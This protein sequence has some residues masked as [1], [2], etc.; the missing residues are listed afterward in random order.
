[1]VEEPL[2][3]FAIESSSTY[4]GL[5]RVL[6]GALAP[7][8]GV[9]PDM[10]R[11]PELLRRAGHDSPA[12]EEVIIATRADSAGNATAMYLWKM[13]LPHRRAITRDSAGLPPLR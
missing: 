11:I 2:D 5:Y 3:V 8:D 13:L 10:L 6:G 12:I 9:G 1:M 7:L 4:R